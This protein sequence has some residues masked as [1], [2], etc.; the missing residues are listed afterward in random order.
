MRMHAHAKVNLVLSVQPGLDGTGYHAVDTVMC[1]LELCDLVYVTASDRPGVRFSCV[2]DPLPAGTSQEKNVAYRAAV[3]MGER[4]GRELHHDIAIEK[5]IPSQAGLGGGSTD[6]AAV[7]R[8]LASLWSIDPFDERLVEVASAL[9][10]D[11]PFFL[12]KVPT[13]LAG[14]GDEPREYFPPFSVPLMLIKPHAGVSTAAAYRLF[15]EL[16]TK[17]PQVDTLVRALRDGDVEAVLGAIANNME[18]AA[19]A[20]CPEL[21]EVEA[22]VAGAPAVTHGPLLCGSGSCM[23]AFVQSDEDAEQM[24]SRARSLGWWATATRTLA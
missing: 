4:F 3:A 21:A 11:V 2:P 15:D 6:A 14:R 5:R 13:L 7:I 24:A 9:G 16:E 18:P 8:A 17:P 20:L 19:V 12:H 1:P 10:A 22:L 23:A